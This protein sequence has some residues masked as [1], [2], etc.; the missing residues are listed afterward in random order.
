MLLG[1]PEAANRIC[2]V[3]PDWWVA[4]IVFATVPPF[5]TEASPEFEREKSKLACGDGVGEGGVASTVSVN[6]V[7][8][9]IEAAV[10]L[11]M[12]VASPAGVEGCVWIVSVVWQSG[13]HEV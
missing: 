7:V 3:V 4:V 9:V 10:A 12:I 6:D 13:L 8:R 2:C 1:R 11:T 5:V